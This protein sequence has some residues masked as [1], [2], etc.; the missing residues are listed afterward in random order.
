MFPLSE[1][2]PFTNTGIKTHRDSLVIDFNSAV[3]E[4][5][6]RRFSDPESS[7]ADV[8]AEFFGHGV[9][10]R[11]KIGDNRDWSMSEARRKAQ[12]NVKPLKEFIRVLEYRPFDRRSI[13]Y[14][15]DLIDFDRGSLM[16]HMEGSQNIGLIATR[17]VPNGDF[18]HAFVTR[19]LIEM[20]TGFARSWHQ[21]LP[22]LAKVRSWFPRNL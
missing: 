8:R 14:S 13:F 7:D 2:M 16:R 4:E 19:S 5:R 10:G 21:P 18:C 22:S 20:K 11:Y 3:L 15:A 12:Q 6:I 1:V 9:R 17:Q